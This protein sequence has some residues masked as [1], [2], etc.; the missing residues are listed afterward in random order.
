MSFI[1]QVRLPKLY[2]SSLVLFSYAVLILL[3]PPLCLPL[4]IFFALTQM[5]SPKPH[6]HW[7]YLGVDGCHLCVLS[8]IQEPAM[9]TPSWIFRT[10][11]RLKES[12]RGSKRGEGIEGGGDRETGGTQWRESV[13]SCC[14]QNDSTGWIMRINRYQ[15]QFGLN[16]QRAKWLCVYARDQLALPCLQYSSFPAWKQNIEEGQDSHQWGHVYRLRYVKF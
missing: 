7:R 3:S 2:P 10:D 8:L 5:L 14:R 1:L 12:D 11:F 15:W 13:K 16:K 6:K 9:Q 4:P